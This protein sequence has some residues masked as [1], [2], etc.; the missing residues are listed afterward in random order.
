MGERRGSAVSQ[1]TTG[2]SG[3]GCCSEGSEM[4]SL[5]RSAKR[6]AG[7]LDELWFWRCACRMVSLLLLRA[8]L[9]SLLL[10]SAMPV[11]FCASTD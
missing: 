4:R 9:W 5:P 6:Y 1:T 7:S 8:W 3:V 10:L 11:P 2:A